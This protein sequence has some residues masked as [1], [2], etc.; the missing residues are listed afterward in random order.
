[1]SRIIRDVSIA[2]FAYGTRPSAGTPQDVQRAQG[3]AQVPL[4]AFVL[5]DV[6][7]LFGGQSIWATADRTAYVQLVGHRAGESGLWEK[8]YRIALSAEQWAEVERLVGAHHL[9]TVKMP[10]RPGV[11]DE[12]HPLIM[13]RSVNGRTTNTRTSIRSTRSCFAC[14]ARGASWFA[15]ARTSG[16]GT[17]PG[18][19]GR[20][21]YFLNV[22]SFGPR[23]VLSICLIAPR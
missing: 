8:R 23:A 20:N 21:R 16:S 3:G 11:P 14:V 5:Q 13:V 18:S 7:G 6:Q 19:S 2:A 9:L 15:K 1:M 10:E 17:R 12:A 22:P 4:K